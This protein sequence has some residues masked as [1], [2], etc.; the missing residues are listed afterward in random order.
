M[1]KILLSCFLAL[2]VYANAQ[3]VPITTLPSNYNFNDLTSPNLP[4][5]WTVA[6]GLAG[7][8]WN[9]W[10][11]DGNYGT[12]AGEKFLNNNLDPN[13]SGDSWVFT[14]AFSFTGGQAYSVTYTS[15]AT[16]NTNSRTLKIAYGPN[17]SP[18]GMS[19]MGQDASVNLTP[20]TSAF[21]FTPA[22]TGT[23]YIGFQIS[24][25]VTESIFSSVLVDNIQIRQEGVLGVSDVAS[26]T[27]IMA[28]PNPVKDILTISN[29]K[30]VKSISVNDM[31]GR[32]VKT[33]VSGNEI[34][35]SNLQAGNYVVTMLMDNGSIQT[36]KTIKK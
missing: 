30:G 16:N 19:V 32:Q 4:A 15:R 35:F 10:T 5:C 33:V 22:T 6:T 36:I 7:K 34:D 9:T 3:C 14:G 24:N 20:E 23:Y 2:G 18:T 28:Y 27:R 11:S 8:D 1:K 12:T 31:S 13:D 25:T 17:A 21:V 26:K 29:I